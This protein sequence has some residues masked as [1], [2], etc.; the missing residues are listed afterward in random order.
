MTARAQM[1]QRWGRR[2]ALLGLVAFL[3]LGCDTSAE[4]PP[5]TTS[6]ADIDLNDLIHYDTKTADARDVY[7]AGECV[8]GATRECRIYLPSHNDVQ[9]CFVGEQLCAGARWGECESGVLVD[10][11][12]DDTELTPADLPK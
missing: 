7:A 12:D 3:A 4:R 8:D 9:P 6:E 5:P 2:P 11:N 1:D 10:A